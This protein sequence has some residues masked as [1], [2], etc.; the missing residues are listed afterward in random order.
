L[1]FCKVGRSHKLDDI[2]MISKFSFNPLQADDLEQLC[3]WLEKP[4]VLE[5]W[6]DNLTRAEIKQ[7]YGSRIGDNIVCPYIAYLDDKPIGFIQ[8]YWA[9]KVGDDWWPNEDE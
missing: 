3:D 4:H 8:Y 7:K 6:N 9:S 5:W 2:L 1:C